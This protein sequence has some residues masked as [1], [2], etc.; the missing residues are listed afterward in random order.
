MGHL[1]P[2]LDHPG[3]LL[4]GF[5][6]FSALLVPPAVRHRNG[7]K[8]P[9]VGSGCVGSSGIRNQPPWGCA[10]VLGKRQS[11]PSHQR[12][13][14]RLIHTF[15]L[16]K[17][18]AQSQQIC[19]MRG[20]SG[21]DA[22]GDG[23]GGL[24]GGDGRERGEDWWPPWRSSG[25]FFHSPPVFHSLGVTS[26]WVSPARSLPCPED[27]GNLCIALKQPICECLFPGGHCSN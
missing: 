16:N 26:T 1:E 2:A 6:P 14:Y 5:Q 7:A 4:A 11:V 19:V 3:H 18:N 8:Q 12:R 24:G 10:E 13:T 22:G 21:G 15:Y 9:N 17:H 23:D 20:D 25:R 27:G